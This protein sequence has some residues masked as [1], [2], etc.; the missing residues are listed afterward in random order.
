MS[1]GSGFRVLGAG[2]RVQGSGCRVLGSGCRVWWYNLL[3]PIRNLRDHNEHNRYYEDSQGTGSNHAPDNSPSDRHAGLGAGA[4]GESQRQYTKDEGQRGHDDGSKTELYRFERRLHDL[5]S[6]VDAFFREFNDQDRVLGGK[7]DQRDQTD[8]RV[9]VVV[10]V[11]KERERKDRTEC[12]DRHCEQHGEWYRPA[13]V[14]CTEEEEHKYDRYREDQTGCVTCLDLL[15][16]HRGEVETVTSRQC[17]CGNLLQ[18]LDSI[19][20]AI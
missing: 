4:F 9:Y 12:P 11:R 16:A 7:A 10:Q 3:L 19:A 6:A 8:L 13:L 1:V 20:A 14:Q 5:H 18:S 17:L 2:F 15:A